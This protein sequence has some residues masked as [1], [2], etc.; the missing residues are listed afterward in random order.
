MSTAQAA[1]LFDVSPSSV[2]RY[3]WTLRQGDSLTPKW[4][5]GRY[6]TGRPRKVD[7]NAQ[8]LLKEDVKQRTQLPLSAKDVAPWST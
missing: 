1:R 4:G 3:A 6:G 8:A 5:T 2:K 7:K